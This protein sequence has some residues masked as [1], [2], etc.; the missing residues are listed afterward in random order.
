ME[1]NKRDVVTVTLSI[2][3]PLTTRLPFTRFSTFNFLVKY[4]S[5]M[6]LSVKKE[7]LNYRVN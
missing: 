7:N 4:H 2:R 3:Q 6:Q 5:R 1:D